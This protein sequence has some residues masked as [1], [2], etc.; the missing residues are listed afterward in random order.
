[1]FYLYL[2]TVLLHF[3]EKADVN[4]HARQNSPFGTGKYVNSSSGRFNSGTE[5]TVEFLYRDIW[6]P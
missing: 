4:P 3:I 6:V 1:M 2:I 5:I